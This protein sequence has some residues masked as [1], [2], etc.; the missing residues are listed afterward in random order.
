M[1]TMEYRSLAGTQKSLN[2][3]ELY[4]VYK[5]DWGNTVLFNVKC[6]TGSYYIL[7]SDIYES[8]EYKQYIHIN[9]T[10]FDIYEILENPDRIYSLMQ[11]DLLKDSIEALP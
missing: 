5:N 2:V 8:S 10:V 4:S 6:E 1:I 3:I 11:Q 7:Y 9:D